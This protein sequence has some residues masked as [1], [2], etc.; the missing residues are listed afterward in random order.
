MVI[1][2]P[3]NIN[4]GNEN[5]MHAAYDNIAA[6]NMDYEKIDEKYLD[7]KRNIDNE[8]RVNEDRYINILENTKL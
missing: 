7:K 6:D 3:N 1:K 8:I 4:I 5:D 2:I